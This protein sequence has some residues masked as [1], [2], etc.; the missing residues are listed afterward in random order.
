MHWS[1]SACPGH[2][3]C[4]FISEFSKSLWLPVWRRSAYFSNI[5]QTAL[6]NFTLLNMDLVHRIRGSVYWSSGATLPFSNLASP[7]EQKA[8]LCLF[9]FWGS[10]C[11][12][13]VL[14]SPL[15]S[16]STGCSHTTCP[17]E[18]QMFCRFN[19]CSFLGQHAKEVLNVWIM[20]RNF[21]SAQATSVL[22]LHDLTEVT[23]CPTV[24]S[25]LADTFLGKSSD[26][27]KQRFST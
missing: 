22:F 15:L 6:C 3:L 17:D 21:P 23:F 25:Q 1:S 12:S 24:K 18:Q 11:R 9:L 14:I 16:F 8:I 26:S 5:N 19:S 27:S 13:P 10:V 20:L 2:E 7:C 4:H